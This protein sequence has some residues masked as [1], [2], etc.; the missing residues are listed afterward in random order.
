MYSNLVY[1]ECSLNFGLFGT[2]RVNSK[3]K[4]AKI[5]QTPKIKTPKSTIVNCYEKT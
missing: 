1:F 3:I 4:H 2:S 5:K